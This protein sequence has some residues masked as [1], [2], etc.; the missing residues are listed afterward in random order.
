MARAAGRGAAVRCY[1]APDAGLLRQPVFIVS[2]PRAGSTLLF[3]MLGRSPHLWT[4]GGES[5]EI[6]ERGLHVPGRRGNVLGAADAT[7]DVTRLVRAAFTSVLRDHRGRLPMGAAAAAPRAPLRLLEKTPKNALRIPFLKAIFPRAKFVYLYREPRANIAS[8]IEG[9]RA[10]GRFVQ[11]QTGGGPWCFLMPPNWPELSGQPH[12]AI[13]AAQWRTANDAI[14]RGLGALD[15]EDWH[16]LDYDDLAARPGPALEAIARFAGLD[17]GGALR[18]VAMGAMPMSSSVLA[19]PHPDKWKRHEAAIGEIW[20]AIRGTVEQ[21]RE[22]R[23][24]QR[25]R[26]QRG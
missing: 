17:L 2:A 8:L 3:E 26:K 16:C 12:H 15:P 11:Y 21:C 19:A 24:A 14:M 1:A 23:S 22:F 20:P 5:H 4:V 13:A 9:W 6:L 18:L 25:H 7:Q 10:G